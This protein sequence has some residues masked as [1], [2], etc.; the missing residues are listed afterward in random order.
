MFSKKLTILVNVF[1]PMNLNM[2]IFR[3]LNVVMWSRSQIGIVVRIV[4][5]NKVVMQTFPILMGGHRTERGMAVYY[6]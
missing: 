3:M 1:E 2:R 6:L 5:G 4:L